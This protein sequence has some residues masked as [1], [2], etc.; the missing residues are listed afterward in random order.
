MVMI[1]TGDVSDSDAGL[2]VDEPPPPW[3]TFPAWGNLPTASPGRGELPF[4]VVRFTG[5]G[6]GALTVERGRYLELCDPSQWYSPLSND[7]RLGAAVHSAGTVVSLGLPLE[8]LGVHGGRSLAAWVNA[9]AE[10]ARL[11]RMARRY[12]ET[13]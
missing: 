6:D 5:Y 2:P 4:E 11:A 3:L 8:H 10:N 13:P 1:L 7:T 9:K 12:R